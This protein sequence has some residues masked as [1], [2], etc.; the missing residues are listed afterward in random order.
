MEQLQRLDIVCRADDYFIRGGCCAIEMA[1]FLLDYGILPEQLLG[2]MISN[3]LNF[4]QLQFRKKRFVQLAFHNRNNWT[5]LM[6]KVIQRGIPLHV[7]LLE[8]ILNLAV[9][10]GN[11]TIVKRIIEKRYYIT[12]SL[13]QE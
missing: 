1:H 13:I 3:V 10:S 2:T 7:D 5:E 8:R 6:W 12:L 9:K 11:L 4:H